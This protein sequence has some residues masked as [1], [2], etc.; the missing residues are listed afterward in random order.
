MF[1]V[2]NPNTNEAL[3][4]QL[5]TLSFSTSFRGVEAIQSELWRR[6]VTQDQY[7]TWLK[8]EKNK[9]MGRV[10]PSSKKEDNS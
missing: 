7:L 2:Q 3:F 5:R 8:K 1:T 9:E 6:G 10:E 4:D